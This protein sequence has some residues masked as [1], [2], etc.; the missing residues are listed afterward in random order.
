VVAML[1]EIF[2]VRLEA[3]TRLQEQTASLS[4]GRFVPFAPSNQFVF[5]DRTARPADPPRE[6]GH[7]QVS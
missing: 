3:A 7:G 1:A 6:A 4:G 5:K 2:M